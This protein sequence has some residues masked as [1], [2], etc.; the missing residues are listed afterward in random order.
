MSDSLIPQTW[1]DAGPMHHPFYPPEVQT[2]TQH[3]SV[4]G[5]VLDFVS[6]VKRNWLLVVTITAAAL[7]FVAFRARTDRPMYR[8]TAVIRVVDKAS[9][10]SGGL[11]QDAPARFRDGGTDPLLSQIQLLQSRGVAREAAQRAG[12]RIIPDNTLPPNVITDINVAPDA[13]SGAIELTFGAS[14]VSARAQGQLVHANYGEP[15]TI[16]GVSFR[17]SRAPSLASARL[18][19]VS[20]DDAASTIIDKLQGRPRDRTN[21]IDV[22]YLASDPLKAQTVV[23]TAVQ[24]FQGLS[25]RND[26]QASM[27]RREFIEQQLAKTE[28]QLSEAQLA[29]NGFRRNTQTYSSQDKFK[30]QQSDLATIELR[31]QDLA[32]DRTVLVGVLQALEDPKTNGALTGERLSALVATPGVSGNAVITSLD[33]E[34]MRLQLSYDSLTTGVWAS[35]PNNPDVKRIRAL[36]ASTDAKMVSAVRGQLAT[37][38]ARISALDDVRAKTQSQLADLPK[39][40]GLEVGLTAQVETFSHEAERLREELQK[41]QIEEAA[42]DGQIDIVDAATLPTKPIGSGRLPK[43][44]FAGL[45]GLLA[46]A[47]L[48]YT[49]ENHRAVIRRRA[50][51]ERI[52][53]ISNLALIPRLKFGAVEAKASNGKSAARLAAASTSNGKSNVEGIKT[54]VARTPQTSELVTLSHDR[55]GGAEAYRTLRTNLLFSAAAQSLKR[56]V[57][58][59]AGPSEG[60]STTAANLGVAFAQQGY[61]VLLIDSDLRRPRLHKIFGS[62]QMPGLTNVLSGGTTAMDAIVQT[63][64]PGLSVLTAGTTPHNPAELLGSPRMREQLDKLAA[65]F[66]VIILDTPPL[67]VT[68]DAAVVSRYSDG[69]LVVVRA[70]TTERQAVQDALKQLSAVGARILGTVLNDPD[71]EAAKY[72]GYYTYSN[73][74]AN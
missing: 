65:A 22:T 35:S 39:Q 64:V 31:R 67:L 50:D 26:R 10:L 44:I 52:T 68:S 32:S 51:L 70:G 42:Q 34:L 16:A 25:A 53:P 66:D 4:L 61:R 15:V 46:A 55:S 8:A 13:P 59:S 6:L 2:N 40:E 17:V 38:E 58:T 33:Q 71:A 9:Q 27:R 73:Y 54:V 43:F 7:G 29:Y 11:G 24:V 1:A 5:L 28:A 21:I 30:N 3:E 47:M 20:T 23:N 74:Y 60:K 48:A 36:I 37:V 72:A 14:S 45:I 56:I 62:A 41:A 19:V 69:A 49:F 12:L 63:S 18:R 57:V